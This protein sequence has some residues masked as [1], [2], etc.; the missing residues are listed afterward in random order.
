MEPI[1]SVIYNSLRY[2]DSDGI[3][4]FHLRRKDWK[5]LKSRVWMWIASRDLKP[6]IQRERIL[7]GKN[8]VKSVGRVNA[9]EKFGLFSVQTFIEAETTKDCQVLKVNPHISFNCF[10]IT[11]TYSP[12][13]PLEFMNMVMVARR[14]GDRFVFT[15]SKPSC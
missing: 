3:V 15:P 6:V 10:C 14:G 2:D 5:K 9:V 7:L 1:C 4:T 8:N 12:W 11:F 13:V